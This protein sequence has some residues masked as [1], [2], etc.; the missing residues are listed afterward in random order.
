[1]RPIKGQVVP[2]HDIVMW[3]SEGIPPVF[4][5]FGTKCR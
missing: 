1:M 3:V 5:N 2:L 4:I